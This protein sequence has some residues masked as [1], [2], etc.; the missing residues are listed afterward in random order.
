MVEKLILE[1]CNIDLDDDNND[2]DSDDLNEDIRN[3]D[4]EYH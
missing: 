2:S 4:S 3:S 1:M